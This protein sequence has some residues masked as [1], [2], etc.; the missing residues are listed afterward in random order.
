MTAP[1]ILLVDGD[2]AV[3]ASIEFMLDIAGFVVTVSH[4]AEAVLA[5]ALA[6]GQDCIVLDYRL[7]GIDGLTLLRRLRRDGIN[8]SAVVIT[9]NPPRRLRRELDEAGVLLIEKPLLS[10][11][12]FTAVDKLTGRT[13]P[14]SP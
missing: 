12:L 4:S 1:H 14:V 5:G 10:D 2:P 11:R 8:C 3:C 9:T 6:V 7:P 13:R